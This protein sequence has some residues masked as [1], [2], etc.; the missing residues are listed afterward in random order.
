MK[1]LKQYISEA[2][3]C[4]FISFQELKELEKFAGRL[5]EKFGI[6]IAFTKHFG[7]RMS[8]SRNTPCIKIEELKELFKKVARDG[9]KKIKRHAN[10]EAVLKDLQSDLNL[11][12]VINV[13]RNG[14][15]E[16]VMKTIM[17]KKNFR[18]PSPEVKYES[19]EEKKLTAA[20]LKKREEI[21]NAI[22]KDDPEM[23]MDKKMAIATSKAKEVSE[24]MGIARALSPIVF[25]ANYKLAA[26][27]LKKL[28]DR[29]KAE[30][31]KRHDDLYYASRIAQSHRGVDARK[32]MKMIESEEYK[33]FTSFRLFKEE[34]KYAK[35]KKEKLV[36]NGK[37]KV[38][39][40]P[41]LEPK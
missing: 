5:L 10:D 1:T 14:E 11:P 29:K 35:A 39:V 36:D 20:E 8:D 2:T 17:R 38:V 32:L 13:D 34:H 33:D 23:S 30:G 41:E 40:N 15:F 27:E 18:T 26:K 19:L 3:G 16:I 22:E 28:L 9:G 37:T 21:A 6:D 31:E 24:D 25:S 12:I 4:D 7:E